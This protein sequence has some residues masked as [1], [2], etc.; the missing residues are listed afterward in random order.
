[1]LEAMRHRGPDGRGMLE[2]PGGAAGMVRLALV[3]LSERGQQ[4]M[5]SADRKTAILFNGEIYNFREER[6]RLEQRG[7]T[8]RTTTDT[9]VVLNLYLE[10]GLEF[11]Q[12]LRGMYAIAMFDWRETPSDGPPVLLLVRGE[13]GIK[14]LYVAHPAGDKQR[15]VFS[16]ELRSLLASELVDR[17]IDQHGLADYLAY[18]FLPQPRTLIEGVR[19]MEPGTWE[20]Y[21]PGR[22]VETK[23]FWSMPEYQPRQES[24][25]EAANRL[26]AVLDESVRIHALADAPIGAFL[27]GGI[28]ST[29]IV[30]LMRPHIPDLRT[31]TLRYADVPGYDESHEAEAAA[32]QFEC[33]HTVVELTGREIAPLIAEFAGAL[34]QPS[35]DGLNT[36]LISRAA[37]EDVTGVLSGLGG[38][39]WFAGYP[40]ARRM[41][42]YCNTAGGRAHALAGKLANIVAPL[43]PRGGVRERAENLATRRS[44]LATWVQTHSV[45]RRDAAKRM[46]GLSWEASNEVELAKM[47][48]DVRDDWRGETPVGLACLLDTRMYMVNQLLRDSDATS[49]SHSLELR[50]PLVDVEVVRFSRSCPDDYKLHASG[51]DGS[52]YQASG[53]KRV[54]IHALRDLLPAEIDRRPKRGFMLPIEHWMRKDFLPV[55]EDAC[56]LGTIAQRGL[57][58]PNVIAPTWKAARAGAPGSNYPKLWCLMIFE[59]WC[60]SVLD[61]PRNQLGRIANLNV[62]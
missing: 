57:I 40:V 59:L 11:V 27:S 37:A 15:V 32:R 10:H 12:R 20:R 54:L 8:F 46:V 36:W 30:G 22:A 16:S 6:A 13:L 38:D 17:Q 48:A 24:F 34:D 25:D 51:G 45:F 49:M 56:S 44:L 18:G 19:M 5:W 50:V 2:Y 52:H 23:K 1:M 58:D 35:T 26:R 62:A 33:Q 47:L 3:D 29:G 41:S 39:E 53:A 7:Y 55:V 60:R 43:L 4:P 42:R 31:Y 9:E 14:P 21:T 28:D 61:A